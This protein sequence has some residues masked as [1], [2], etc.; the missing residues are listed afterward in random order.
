MVK[1]DDNNRNDFDVKKLDKFMKEEFI[2]KNLKFSDLNHT[3]NGEFLYPYVYISDINKLGFD[4]NKRKYIIDFLVGAS[5]YIVDNSEIIS[6]S[7]NNWDLNKDYVDNEQMFNEYNET[8][9]PLIREKLILAN[10]GL[11]SKISY[12]YCLATGFDIDEINSYGYEGLINAVDKYKLDNGKF[13]TF[14]TSYIRGYILNGIAE[15]N[16]FDKKIYSD[17]FRS[18]SIVEKDYATNLYNDLNMVDDIVDLMTCNQK[19]SIRRKNEIKSMILFNMAESLSIYDIDREKIFVGT[20]SYLCFC[21]VFDLIKKS[22]EEQLDTLTCNEKV[23]IKYRYGFE[24]GQ[25]MT[26]EEIAKILNF[27]L[28]NIRKIEMRAICKLRHKSRNCYL[29]EWYQ[30]LSGYDSNSYS[31][32]GKK[33]VKT[34]DDY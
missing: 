33:M 23:V 19:K 5:I 21:V 34:T 9:N 18:R 7:C 28:Q 27:S 17:Y 16:G 10:M 24:T 26:Y 20:D 31:N 2:P 3:M 8:H 6:K 22:I 14:A 32:V 11:L 13:S 25:I 29:K 1:I 12:K 4:K 30:Y 15:M